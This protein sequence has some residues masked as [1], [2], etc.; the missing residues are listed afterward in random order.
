MKPINVWTLVGAGLLATVAGFLISNFAI[1][2]GYPIPVSNLSL[3]FSIVVVSA[4]LFVLALPIARYKKQLKLSYADKSVTSLRPVP[5]D[6]FYAVRVLVL[7]K[8]SAITAA[9]FIGWHIGVI[10]KLFTLPVLATDSLWPNVIALAVSLILLIV[11]FLVQRICKL[12]NDPTP[13]GG[14]P[15]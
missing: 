6:P 8:A 14:V 5:V 2:N 13:K 7:S 1:A 15:A 11:A 10:V 3:S 9:L 4:V 12:P